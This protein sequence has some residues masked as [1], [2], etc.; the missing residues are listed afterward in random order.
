MTAGMI[1]SLFSLFAPVFS[2]CEAPDLLP[3]EAPSVAAAGP[4]D[5]EH[6]RSTQGGDD[7]HF[8]IGD[9]LSLY[10]LRTAVVLRE[11]GCGAQQQEDRDSQSA[12]QRACTCKSARVKE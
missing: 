10:D 7:D 5:N 2:W 6:G 11:C 4:A 3:G 1:H 8:D 12:G 9:A